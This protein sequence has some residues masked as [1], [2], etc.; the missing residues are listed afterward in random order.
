MKSSKM[1]PVIRL[2]VISVLSLACVSY[3]SGFSIL[4]RA[5]LVLAVLWLV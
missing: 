4:S 1:L 3:G 2:L 5:P